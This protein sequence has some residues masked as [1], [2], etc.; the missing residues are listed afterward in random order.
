MNNNSIPIEKW[1]Y[2]C[3]IA[4]LLNETIKILK[5]NR[6]I[7][8][9]INDY[10]VFFDLDDGVINGKIKIG[11]GL[12]SENLEYVDCRYAKDFIMLLII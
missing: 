6:S 7:G 2:S 12:S 11:S 4:I 1:S 3:L 10:T 5:D 8:K 9:N